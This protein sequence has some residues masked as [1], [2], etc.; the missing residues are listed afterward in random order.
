MR[1][2]NSPFNRDRFRPA[3]RMSTSVEPTPT[4]WWVG[5]DR[6]AFKE[7]LDAERPRQA[8]QKPGARDMQLGL[9]P[10]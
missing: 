7:A 10:R 3:S 4:S 9:V 8:R 2:V 1:A 6:A 5:K